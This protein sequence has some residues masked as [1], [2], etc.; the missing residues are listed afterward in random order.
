MGDRSKLIVTIFTVLIVAVIAIVCSSQSAP[1]TA[2]S[3]PTDD[4]SQFYLQH[5]FIS[6]GFVPADHIDTNLVNA[7]GLVAGP[8]TP[9]WI[10][11]NRTGKTPLLNVGS[12]TIVTE[13]TV[14]G[15]GGA[16]GNPTGVVF[17]GG[18]GF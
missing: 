6:D 17:N 11:D 10:A 1:V 12:N 14:P 15:A 7:W 16:Q 9:W 8:T 13:F 18:S 3:K 4:H 5:N 2:S